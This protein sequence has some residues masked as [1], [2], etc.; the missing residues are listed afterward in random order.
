[1]KTTGYQWFKTYAVM[2]LNAASLVATFVV[3]SGFGFAF[4]WVAA[5]QLSQIAVGFA[6]AAVSAMTLLATLCMLGLGT[7][8][9]RELPRQPGQEVALI[10]AALLLVGIVGGCG[11]FFF[12]LGIPSFSVDLL[13]LRDSVLAIVL[14]AAGV[15]F[16]TVNL[17]LDQVL[18]GLLWGD[19]QLWRNLLFAGAKLLLLA[20]A[21]F[22]LVRR[23]G[24]TIYAAWALGDVFS[25][26]VLIGFVRLKRKWSGRIVVPQWTLLR[27]LGP[28]A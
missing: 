12:A 2:L 26:L 28:S 11:G 10:S 25:L 1:M 9:I 23:G 13:P 3:K 16:A 24:L 20:V 21:G 6:S 15:S 5:H 18:I 17:V 22:L 19:L 4:W 7:L 8:L 27:K 14:F